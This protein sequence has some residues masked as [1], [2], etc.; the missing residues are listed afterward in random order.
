MGAEGRR[1]SGADYL[2][3]MTARADLA[4][5]MARFH[6]RY[7]LLLTPTL[8]I[9]AFEAGRDTPASGAWGERWIDWTP[10]SYPFNLTWQPAASCPCGLTREGLPIGLQIVGPPR[11]DELV[12]RAAR[13]FESARPFP[14]IE[15]PRGEAAAIV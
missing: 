12:L 5:R 3:A 11:R 13:A 15:A 10:Y 7:D 1:I 9:P 2:R 4:L 6:E 14:T 8:P